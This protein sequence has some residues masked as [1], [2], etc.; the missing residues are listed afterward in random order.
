MGLP[1]TESAG[2][3]SS[4]AGLKLANVLYERRGGIAYVTVNRPKALN[5]LNTRTWKD[6]RAVFED[7]RDD[8]AIRGAIL[9]GSGDRAF[10][11]GADI[12]ELATL[13]AFE[14]AR[15]SLFGQGVLDLIENLGKPVI[16]AV[17]GFALGGGCETAMACTLRI[18]VE[19]ASFGQPEVK[20]GLLP[21]GGG[22]Q[23]LPRLVG[24][25]RA[26][27]LILSGEAIAA[28]EAWRIGLINEVVSAANLIARAEA[29]LK[30]IVA[31]API[32]VTLALEA[33]NR[34]LETSQ[35]QGM[36]LEAS[37]FGLCA[38]TDDKRE[39][40]KAFLERRTPEFHGR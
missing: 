10:I 29:I 5:S 12:A 26:L 9:T 33:T 39:G 8:A 20:L 16:A 38:A 25:G 28:Q 3:S 19:H 15:A 24:K 21:G 6:L 35:H 37:Y 40:T 1:P 31:N 36:L 27:H 11:A 22:T 17:N 23:R 13:G 34:G 2:D 18:A 7:V 14:A 30:Q 4:A 32:A